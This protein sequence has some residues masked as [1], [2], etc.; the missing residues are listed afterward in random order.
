[1]ITEKGEILIHDV[2]HMRINFWKECL[3]KSS[4]RNKANEG[5]SI[6]AFHHQI[7]NAVACKFFVCSFW[8]CESWKYI[9]CVSTN[10]QS[11]FEQIKLSGPNFQPSLMEKANLGYTHRF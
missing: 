1:M 6:N 11:D 10:P 2:F 8:F 4:P 7:S 5:I 9:E 3:L